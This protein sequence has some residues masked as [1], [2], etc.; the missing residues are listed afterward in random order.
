MMWHKPARGRGQQPARLP[1]AAGRVVWLPLPPPQ[2][3]DASL[4]LT[5]LPEFENPPGGGRCWRL[6]SC[7]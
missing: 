7:T 1:G 2:P 6:D 4:G 3:L 5:I